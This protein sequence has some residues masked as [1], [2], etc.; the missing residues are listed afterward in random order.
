MRLQSIM[1]AM[2]CLVGF[3][4]WGASVSAGGTQLTRQ[5]IA[6]GLNRPVFV[7]HIPGD[8]NRLFVV[9]QRGVIRIIKD[10]QLLPTP[11]LDIDALV[12]FINGNSEQGLLGLAFHPN[13]AEN[14]F[15]Y[16]NYT[17]LAGNTTIARFRTTP[18]PDIADPSGPSIVL[19][20]DQPFSNHNGGWLDFGPDG[21]LYIGT[22]DGGL[23]NDPGNRAQDITD[24]LLGKMLRI[25]I[26]GFD[27]PGGNYAIPPDNPFVGMTGDDEIWAYGLRNPWRCSFDRVTGDLYIG[28][29]GQDAVEEID[30]Q[31]ADSTG[32]ENYGWRCMEGNSCTGLTGCTCGDPA[33]TDPIQTYGH[34]CTTGGFSLTGGYVYRGCTIPDLHGTYFYADFVCSNIWSF[35]VV[36]G[37]VTELRNRD[38]ELGPVSTVA[39]FGEDAYGEIYIVQRGGPTTGQ[40]FKIV[41]AGGPETDCNGNNAADACD[42]LDASSTD[43]NGNGVPDECESL[44]IVSSDPPDNAID[45]RQPSEPDGSNP[46]GWDGIQL[47]FNAD[48][49]GVTA[50]D[51]SIAVDPPGAAPAIDTVTTDGNTATI[52]FDTFIPTGHWT[53]I[54]HDPSGSGVRIGYLPADVGG[55][56]VSNAND[57]LALIDALNGVGDPLP[58]YQTDAD[59]SGIANASDVLRVIDLL[60]G[61]GVYDV[62]N[63]QALP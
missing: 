3:H 23:G 24:Q 56:G 22:G 16:A 27:A 35:R 12:P 47:T 9:E 14:G 30:F 62:W 54:T 20:I 32:G 36:N 28:D 41:P 46:A 2:C 48:A 51:F 21:F 61:A 37:Q 63:G 11:F 26:N 45:A 40:I 1:S 52:A 31:P 34:N 58:L 5:L 55:D 18:D 49:G 50:D 53:V 44:S 29:V 25:D 38:A 15:F 59:R 7:T 57:V 6:S 19:T 10:G 8:F 60:N 13:Y 42:I 43:N 17:N 33:L 4:A 39:S